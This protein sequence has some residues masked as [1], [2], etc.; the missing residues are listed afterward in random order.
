[1][2]ANAEIRRTRIHRNVDPAAGRVLGEAS[3]GIRNRQQPSS[4]PDEPPSANCASTR[5]T[6]LQVLQRRSAGAHG[7]RH[8]RVTW[9]SARQGR[10]AR[11]REEAEP[12]RKASSG[13]YALAFTDWAIVGDLNALVS[14]KHG[15]ALRRLW[16]M[17][18]PIGAARVSGCVF[19]HDDCC[20]CRAALSVVQANRGE[21]S[22]RLPRITW[23]D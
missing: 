10:E 23:T 20:G 6:W 9:S 5:L 18:E 1:M 8:R 15:R 14:R 16:A 4:A 7:S 19:E 11:S 2:Q 17:N 12:P 13:G 21:D 22:I 3:S